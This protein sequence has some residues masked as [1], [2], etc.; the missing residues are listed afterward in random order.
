MG[1]QS[2]EDY[3]DK[4][5]NSVN[6]DGEIAEE[7]VFEETLFETEP[8]EFSEIE[9]TEQ[10]D[11][12]DFDDIFGDLTAQAE[13][14]VQ[15][16]SKRVSRSEADFL[17]E[18]EAELE[19]EDFEDVLKAFDEEPEILPEDRLESEDI[20]SPFSMF[21]QTE[22][23]V[24]D[25]ESSF[26]IPESLFETQE[27]VTEEVSGLFDASET[28]DVSDTFD[29]SE[30]FGSEKPVAESTDADDAF[31]DM[32]GGAASPFED[33]MSEPSEE[34]STGDD[35]FSLGGVDLGSL[36]EE[37]A[38]SSPESNEP[39]PFDMGDDAF[40]SLFGESDGSS[41]GALDLG[42]MG[43][44]D[45]MSLLSGDGLG[46]IGDMLS[47]NDAGEMPMGELDAFSAF[48]EG[49]MAANAPQDE[50]KG[51]KKASKG[52]P[53]G[54]LEK[55]STI[56]FGIDEDEDETV[57]VKTKNAPSAGD[58]SNE[59][60]AILASMDEEEA[61]KKKKKK[62]DKKEKKPKKEKKEKKPKAPKKPKEPK[63]KKPK[64]P[65]EV[66]NTPPLKKGPVILIFLMVASLFALVMLGTNL[67]GYAS[68][69]SKA[70]ALRDGGNYAAAYGELFGL[71][72]KPDDME[73][74]NQ[75]ATLAT[76]DS[77]LNAFYLFLENDRSEEALDSLICAAGRCHINEDNAEVYGCASE[78]E[79][80]RTEVSNR[81]SE[82][83]NM[84][85]EEAIELY[86][87]KDRDD[88]TIALKMKMKELGIITE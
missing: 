37:P 82:Y 25:S 17:M 54:F 28:S 51:N 23:P 22:E 56:L 66:D 16:A 79:T 86:R 46:D 50:T 18:F 70:K 73:L 33:V 84:T 48:A 58:L 31:Q 47:Q 68:T 34:T 80:L 71:E 2:A 78:M 76:V 44:A 7:S 61:G 75:V 6:G 27:T 87:L 77:E 42:N 64:K 43:E 74:Y 85:Y 57:A 29:V 15:M 62:K 36:F 19:G 59:N 45:L 5:L 24:A 21:E 10:E 35:S 32:F 1:K 14:D 3:L 8:M 9:E 38:S 12:F 30:L 53:G 83:Y 81:L 11:T 52:K 60:A 20:T 55:L 40:A 69:I 49:E 72:I 67:V 88:Y 63:A 13:K 26:E 4:L 65:V 41:G 39:I